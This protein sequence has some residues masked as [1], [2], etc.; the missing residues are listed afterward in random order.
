L[1]FRFLSLRTLLLVFCPLYPHSKT[2]SF[3]AQNSVILTIKIIYLFFKKKIRKRKILK[4]E[5]EEE[6]QGWL[7][8]LLGRT[9]PFLAKGWLE[10]PPR[11]V[12]GT[13]PM[14]KGVVQPPLKGKKKKK[15]DFRLLRVAG[16]LPR[17][18]WRW[19]GH[20]KKLKTFFFLPFGVAEPSRW[21]W[22]WFDQP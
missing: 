16:P 22:E 17:A 9:T 13:T 18:P 15:M 8:P 6:N 11:P 3:W 2:T 12:W 4:E 5:E 20:P 14:A 21:P 10:P 7:Q 1:I 19:F